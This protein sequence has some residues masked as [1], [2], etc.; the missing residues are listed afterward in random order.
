MGLVAPPTPRGPGKS[1]NLDNQT[2]FTGGLNLS[3]DQLELKPNESPDLLN[4]DL[5]A[6]GGFRVRSG[7]NQD[8]TA[9]TVNVSNGELYFRGVFLNKSHYFGAWNSL[10]GTAWTA[11]DSFTNAGSQ[12]ELER[13][14][15]IINDIMVTGLAGAATYRVTGAAPV[16]T[17]LT[18]SGG[19][20]QD[21]YAVPSGAH[22]PQGGC[23]EAH[24]GYMFVGNVAYLAGTT[25]PNRVHWSHPNDGA[26]YRSFDYVDVG[27][28]T[29]VVTGLYSLA[30]GNQLLITK[31][32]S[33]WVLYGTDPDSFTL[34]L[35]SDK[36]GAANYVGC[37]TPVGVA[38]FDYNLGV[39]LYDGKEIRWIYQKIARSMV[40]R[41]GTGP[42]PITLTTGTQLAWWGGTYANLDGDVRPR[43]F[44]QT[45]YGPSAQWHNF[46]WDPELDA[47]NGAWTLYRWYTTGK[48][49]QLLQRPG[50]LGITHQFGVERNTTN[51]YTYVTPLGHDRVASGSVTTEFTA[52]YRTA[53]Y[54]AGQP[55]IRK[56]WKRP[57][58]IVRTGFNSDATTSIMTIAVYKDYNP[59]TVA[60]TLTIA[61]GQS[62]AQFNPDVN[63]RGSSLGTARAISMKIT[64]PTDAQNIQEYAW[65][66]SSLLLKFRTKAPRS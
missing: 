21:D 26:S 4:V 34:V 53:W 63:V 10:S 56:T 57:E 65:Y 46:V 25:F 60:K 20:W 45:Q 29:E 58:F 15:A 38:F 3:A 19:V 14:S 50:P 5:D 30:G 59:S 48:N 31:E 32:H 43:L 18:Q 17:L 7:I 28:K 66:V 16:R 40:S 8:T 52:Y 12:N 49:I 61:T 37:K 55:H 23:R 6:S 11:P 1:L 47:G 64:L 51:W 9:G 22:S 41:S 44:F 2:D 35:L 27:D 33:C 39:V 13:C 24:R 36:I 54:T 62:G 42:G